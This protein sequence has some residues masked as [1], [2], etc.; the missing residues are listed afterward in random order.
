MKKVVLKRRVAKD[1]TEKL[2]EH[3]NHSRGFVSNKSFIEDDP[4]SVSHRTGEEDSLNAAASHFIKV[5]HA[6]HSRSDDFHAHV[7]LQLHHGV[8]FRWTF[9][10][11]LQA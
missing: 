7:C 8:V 1:I 5:N 3:A 9:L 10:H 4:L 2:V 11:V 6:P